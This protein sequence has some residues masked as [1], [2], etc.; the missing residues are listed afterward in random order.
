M[1]RKVFIVSTALFLAVGTLSILSSSSSDEQS[2]SPMLMANA[3]ALSQNESSGCKWAVM[4]DNFGVL[5]HVCI[6]TGTGNPCT[7]GDVQ[8]TTPSTIL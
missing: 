5:V 2:I 6:S 4:T 7:C 8:Y 3:E 1:K